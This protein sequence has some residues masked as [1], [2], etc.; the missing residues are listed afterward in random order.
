LVDDP[1]PARRY[2]VAYEGFDPAVV[3][4]YGD[5]DAERLHRDARIIRNRAKIASSINNAK[6]FVSVQE[7]FGSFNAYIWAFVGGVSIQNH[8]TSWDEIP[9]Q[10]SLSIEIS[11]D[12]K[13]HGFS[14]VGPTIV[15]AHMQATGMVNDHCVGCHRHAELSGR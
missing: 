3:A 15:Y 10:T 6:A 11:G 12:L 1:Q 8:W 7:E 13:S 2:R 5:A 9:P 14:F 4:A